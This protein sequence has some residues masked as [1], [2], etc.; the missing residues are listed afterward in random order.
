MQLI[1][2]AVGAANWRAFDDTRQGLALAAVCAVVAPAAELVIM[3]WLGLW[4]YPRPDVFGTLGFPS[5]WVHWGRAWFMTCLSLVCFTQPA[6]RSFRVPQ[7]HLVLFLLHP[8]SGAPGAM[9]ME[10]S[11]KLTSAC[12]TDSMR[13]LQ[14]AVIGAASQL[15]SS[16]CL[17]VKRKVP[18]QGFL[19]SQNFQH[20]KAANRTAF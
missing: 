4:H 9:V 7:G 14:R 17:P 1:L 5:W 20:R 13:A 3:R 11:P 8:S 19:D 10:G 2:A 15:V 6:T 16:C 12:R 18:L